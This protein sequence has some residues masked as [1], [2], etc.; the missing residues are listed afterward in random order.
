[1]QTLWPLF[2]DGVQLLKVAEPLLRDSLLFTITSS[3]VYGTHL[4]DIER[5]NPVVLESCSELQQVFPFLFHI[6]NFPD[7]LKKLSL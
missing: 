7:R 2:M 6:L 5:S 3:G 4:I 1:M